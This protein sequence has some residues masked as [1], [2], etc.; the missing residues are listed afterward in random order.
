[1]TRYDDDFQRAQSTGGLFDLSGWECLQ[2]S[3]RDA[4]DYLNR[5]STVSFRPFI[6]DKIHYCAFLTGRAHAISLGYLQGGERG[7][8]YWVP[9]GNGQVVHDHLEKF[10]FAE[11]L[12]LS[13]N[14]EAALLG[15]WNSPD[16]FLSQ[17]G[18]SEITEPLKPVRFSIEGH[19]VEAWRDDVRPSLIFLR[20]TSGELDFFKSHFATF[21]LP[22]LDPQL[23]EYYRIQARVPQIGVEVGDADIILEA[24]ID[25]AV[26]RNKGCYP[27]QEVVERIFTYGKV[28]RKLLCVRVDKYVPTLPVLFAHGENTVGKIVSVARVPGTFGAH[29]AWIGLAYVQIKYWDLSDD[30]LTPE[31]ARVSILR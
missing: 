7:F 30:C 11:R 10:H 8:E 17:W 24:N 22:V 4:D 14:R 9:S 20:V 6:A 28:N 26:A 16:R 23:F 18:A 25:R 27:G 13:L 31:G 19:G 29:P 2:I 15:V 1:M 3:G 21:N 5:M 12:E